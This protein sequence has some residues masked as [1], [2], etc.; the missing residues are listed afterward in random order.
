MHFI[1]SS[2]EALLDLPPSWHFVTQFTYHFF[3]DSLVLLSRSILFP[4]WGILEAST[5]LGF[6]GYW[7]LKSL[8]SFKCYG[9]QKH[10][11]PAG[12]FSFLLPNPCSAGPLAE[13]PVGFSSI[14]CCYSL[15]HMGLPNLHCPPGC[16][17]QKASVALFWAV[18]R[19]S[20]REACLSLLCAW[21]QTSRPISWRQC[22]PKRLSTSLRCRG[23]IDLEES[24][25][26]SPL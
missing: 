17:S 3:L 4:T 16:Q 12:T 5:C 15:T 22:F 8:W 1:F 20:C 14:N 25:F 24:L 2:C 21:L 11:H 19:S 10:Y 9:T 18:T 7:N 26:S 23:Q 6:G 13:A